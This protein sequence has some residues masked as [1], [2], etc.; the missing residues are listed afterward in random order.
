MISGRFLLRI[1]SVRM[2]KMWYFTVYFQRSEKNIRQRACALLTLLIRK[3]YFQPN[4]DQ[5]LQPKYTQDE[6]DQFLLQNTLF[7]TFFRQN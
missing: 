7:K 4:I 2:E 5:K 6:T 1:I 3:S